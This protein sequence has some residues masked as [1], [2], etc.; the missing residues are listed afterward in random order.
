MFDDILDPLVSVVTPSLNHAAYIGQ[1]IDSVLA[2]DYPNIEYTIID[3]GSTDGTLA[4][5]KQYSGRITWISEPDQGLYDAM[6]KGWA[7]SHGEFVGYLNSDDKLCPGAIGLMVNYLQEHP[8]TGLVYGDYYRIDEAGKVLERVWSGDSNL[9]TLLRHGNTI[10][11]G[12]MLLRR[13]LL[14]EVGWMD[15]RLKYAADYD[16]CARVA[17]QHRIGHIHQPLAMFRIHTGSKS[18]NSRWEMW[19]ETLDVSYKYSHRKHFSLYSRY[20][21]DRI[22]HLLPQ[23]FLWQPSLVMIRKNL[24]RLWKLGG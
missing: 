1:A 12:A 8:D 15:V 23:S 6:N 4:I 19:R 17:R 11:T 7:L 18:Q 21:V 5:L 2:Q 14:E 3:G 24:R 20:F 16:F 9:E 22:V 13:S 10:F